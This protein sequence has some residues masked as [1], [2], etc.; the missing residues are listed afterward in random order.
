M[1]L[2]IPSKFFE[3]IKEQSNA[4]KV[5]WMDWF[6]G[7]AE[8]ILNSD[9]CKNYTNPY[10]SL[11]DAKIKEVWEFGV[12]LLQDGFIISEEEKKDEFPMLT[13]KILDYLNE[14][15]GTSFTQKNKETKK[16]IHA[17]I[18]E[19]YSYHDFITVIEKKCKHWLGTSQEKYL[20]PT[21][22]FLPSKF[23]IYLNEIDKNTEN[24]RAKPT[25]FDKTKSAVDK[26]K[27]FD[28]GLG[29]GQ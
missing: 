13:Q 23:E 14:M 5:L 15:A 20:R 10:P 16:L 21:T 9:F 24:G 12:A 26:A 22:L 18:T 27:G 3:A 29:E 1:I 6:A 7:Y 28:F 8:Q 4:H 25:A 11:S 19:G 17:R 2:N